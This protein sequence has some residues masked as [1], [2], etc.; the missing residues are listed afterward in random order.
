[1]I[2]RI[3]LASALLCSCLV[4]CSGSAPGVEV[5][6]EDGAARAD[7]L[8][9]E[10]KCREA[11][12]QYEELL[13]QFP[14]PDVAE[15]ARFNRSKCRVE[16]KDYD[17]AIT[18]FEDF[19]DSYPKSDLVDDAMYMIAVCYLAQSP[20]AERDQQNTVKAVGELDFLL[21]EY[22]DSNVREEVEALR[23]EARAKLAEKE[24][25]NGKL[26][27][28]LEYFR[29][30]R[31]YFD[32]VINEYGDTE[33]AAW[34]MLG[35]AQTYDR[36]GNLK[37]AIEIYE[38]VIAHYPDTEPSGRAGMRLDQISGGSDDGKAE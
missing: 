16:L 29:A 30:A 22:P 21:R 5:A 18:E 20:R 6:P 13:S 36:E 23:R 7:G 4:A 19:I 10:G 12:I 8:A 31:I 33:W 24:Y 37:K 27:L 14:P 35:K 32:A 25:L 2:Q 34:S 15:R 3:A 28:R 26:Y 11:I 38:K 1:M 17:L 9:A